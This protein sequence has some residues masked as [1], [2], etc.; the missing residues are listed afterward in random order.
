MTITTNCILPK[1]CILDECMILSHE[2]SA[3]K[4]VYAFKIGE[5][6]RKILNVGGLGL[7]GGGGVKR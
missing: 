4:I 6:W 5:H 1:L 2:V 3:R 7:G